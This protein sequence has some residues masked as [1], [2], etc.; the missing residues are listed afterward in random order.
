MAN[1]TYTKD[2]QGDQVLFT[3]I[4]GGQPVASARLMVPTQ[5]FESYAVRSSHRGR[6]LSYALTYAM[7]VYCNKKGYTNPQVSNAHGALLTALPQVGFEQVGPT[8]VIKRGESAASFRCVSRGHAITRCTQKLH[9]YDVTLA[10]P[11]KT[12]RPCVIL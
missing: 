1:Y 9:D 6:G 3:I 7:L 2:N 8:R 5:D 11:I 4:S 12:S 10:G